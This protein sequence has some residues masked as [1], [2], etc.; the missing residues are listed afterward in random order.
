[1]EASDPDHLLETDP[2]LVVEDLLEDM[3]KEAVDQE[4]V[5]E[6]LQVDLVGM[7]VVVEE[8]V[9]P[10]VARLVTGLAAKC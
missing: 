10:E 6:D 7:V 4:V 2:G 3:E 1:M 8:E 9:D 5:L